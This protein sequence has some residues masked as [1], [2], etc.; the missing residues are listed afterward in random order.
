MIIPN[1]T[2]SVLRGETTDLYGDPVDTDTVV[3]PVPLLAT[4][5]QVSTRTMDQSTGQLQ[6][7]RGEGFQ[8]DPG[9]FAFLE[10]DRLRDESTGEVFQVVDVDA[11]AAGLMQGVINLRC[12]LVR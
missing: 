3:T 10:D 2:V 4:R 1:T 6:V 5:M 11:S 9:A 7:F 8:L 12:T